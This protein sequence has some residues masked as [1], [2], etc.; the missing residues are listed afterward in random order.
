MI[1]RDDWLP[2]PSIFHRKSKGKISPR[3]LIKC[4]DCKNKLE[5][6]H[7][8]EDLEING[9]LAS[10]KEWKKILIPLLK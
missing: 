7:G 6:Y 1:K 3:Y 10:K 8:D 9:V 2:V 4:G 5:I